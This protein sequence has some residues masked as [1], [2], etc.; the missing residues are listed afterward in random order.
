MTEREKDIRM[1]LFHETNTNLSTKNYSK[2]KR[3]K[4]NKNIM[5]FKMKKYHRISLLFLERI[6]VIKNIIFF[7]IYPVFSSLFHN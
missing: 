7:F 1:Q 6:V 2:I 4:D 5:V 3:I